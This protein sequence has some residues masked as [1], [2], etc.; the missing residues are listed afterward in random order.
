MMDLYRT[1]AADFMMRIAKTA[2]A[3]M[4][5]PEKLAFLTHAG[6]F[7]RVLSDYCEEMLCGKAEPPVES[8][9]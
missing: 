5:E 9:D 8:T 7:C 4:D 6:K 2:C 3:N 1:S